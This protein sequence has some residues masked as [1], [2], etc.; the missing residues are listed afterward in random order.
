MNVAFYTDQTISGMTGGIGRVTDVLTRYFREQLGWKV[1]SIYAAEAKADCVRT[2]VD[3]AVR[4][5]LHDRLGIRQDA[6]KNVKRAVKWLVEQQVEV[7]IVQ[8]SMEVVAR[9][10]RQMKRQH[11]DI[12]VIGVLHF[13]P[14]K[15]EW[16]WNTNTWLVK[17]AVADTRNYLVHKATQ[18]G[19]RSAL[20]EGDAVGLLSLA[21]IEPYIAFTGLLGTMNMPLYGGKFFAIP[22]PLSFPEILPVSELKNKEKMVLVVARMMESQKRISLIL[23]M[24]HELQDM[25]YR[26]VLV[27]DGPSLAYYKAQ[28]E[29][30]ELKNITF[31]G[32]QDPQPYYRKAQI[33]L[34]TSAFEGFPMTLAEAQQHGCVPV[35]YSSFAALGDVLTHEQNGCIVENENEEA[36]I[37]QVKRLMSDEAY[38]NQL[39]EGA[40]RDC[41]RF[42]IEHVG[43]QWEQILQG[44]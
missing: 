14:G 3:G 25:G 27:G 18:R 16:R 1:Y 29:A 10:K 24:W 12:K 36:Y 7:M 23:N 32:L 9:L 30:L 20:M 33:F 26:L 28:A 35:A 17:R 8:T 22:N 42:T 13:E 2:Q 6:K 5:R 39:A 4:M 44:L 15:D 43:Q 38:R 40:L 34:M 37:A 31:E 21:Y 41:Q 19:Y 11:V